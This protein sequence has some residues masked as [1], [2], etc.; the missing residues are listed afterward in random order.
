[1][2]LFNRPKVTGLINI[3]SLLDILV[4]VENV[5][6]GALKTLNSFLNLL[7][8]VLGVIFLAALVGGVFG[9][10]ACRQNRIHRRKALMKNRIRGKHSPLRSM[11]MPEA[12]SM[13]RDNSETEEE[14]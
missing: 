12:D 9:I 2:A 7:F 14:F 13:L 3:I 11:T 4:V 5:V 1:M 8:V 10:A 6:I